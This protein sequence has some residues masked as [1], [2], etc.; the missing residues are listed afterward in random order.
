MA[1]VGRSKFLR[2]VRLFAC[3]ICLFVCLFDSGARR[4]HELHVYEHTEMDCPLR[5]KI[6]LATG[7]RVDVALLCLLWETLRDLYF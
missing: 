7:A 1:V 2:F 4:R 6:P 3:Y 5:V